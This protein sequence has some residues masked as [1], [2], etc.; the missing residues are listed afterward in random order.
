MEPDVDVLLDPADTLALVNPALT[1]FDT[2]VEFVPEFRVDPLE[3]V[4][5]V[6]VVVD[7]RYIRPFLPSD[8]RHGS[9][10]P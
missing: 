7:W 1:P 10:A 6:V 2:V 3:L 4:V 9:P 8:V 5:V